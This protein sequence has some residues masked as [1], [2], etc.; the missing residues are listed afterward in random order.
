MI[1]QGRKCTRETDSSSYSPQPLKLLRVPT[2][3]FFCKTF[4]R[5]GLSFCSMILLLPA[6][7]HHRGNSDVETE[8]KSIAVPAGFASVVTLDKQVL[9]KYN[10]SNNEERVAF[11]ASEVPLL[12]E[13]LHPPAACGEEIIGQCTLVFL[14]H[15]P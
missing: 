10:S 9:I 6:I 14:L 4:H 8:D 11:G 5:I 13:H 7:C 2:A 15:L 1:E 3:H 12:H